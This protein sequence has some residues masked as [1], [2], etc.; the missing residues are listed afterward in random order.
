MIDGADIMRPVR[1][2]ARVDIM[3]SPEIDVADPHPDGKRAAVIK[4]AAPSS[5]GQ[6]G[7]GQKSFQMCDDLKSGL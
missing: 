3:C 4:A 7:A 2:E 6:G 1:V 5:S